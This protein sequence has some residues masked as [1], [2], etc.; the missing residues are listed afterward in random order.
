MRSTIV[1]RHGPPARPATVSPSQSPMRERA[2]ASG[3][4]SEGS[5]DTLIFPRSSESLHRLRR[6]PPRLSLA[7]ALRPPMQRSSR[8]ERIPRQ[9]VVSLIA[10]SGRSSAILPSSCSGDQRPS[11]TLDLT[12]SSRSGS[13]SRRGLRHA[14]LRPS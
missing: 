13:S 4:R 14:S 6:R 1:T 7:D 9:I 3:G 11:S 5:C 8:P 12:S 2:P 10:R